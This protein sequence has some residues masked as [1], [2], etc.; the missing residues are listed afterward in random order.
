M[1]NTLEFHLIRA[2]AT[3]INTWAIV[4]RTLAI[5]IHNWATII[6][7]WATEQQSSTSERQSSALEQQS[8]APE[9]K[10]SATQQHLILTWDTPRSLLSYTSVTIELHL[11]YNELHN[12]KNLSYPWFINLKNNSATSQRQLSSIS[13]TKELRLIHNWSTRTPHLQLTYTTFTTKQP[14]IAY[15]ATSHSL[16]SYTSSTAELHLKQKWASPHLKELGY[17]LFTHYISSLLSFNY[18]FSPDDNL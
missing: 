3:I 1:S 16:S 15:W 13:F 12:I 2:W 6:C 4:I 8:S 7:T 11:I 9:E 14:F 5:V 18:C 17:V 10:S